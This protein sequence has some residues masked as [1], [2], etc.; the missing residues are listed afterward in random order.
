M[1]LNLRSARLPLALAAAAGLVA[2]VANI[3]YS[4][5]KDFVAD[6]TASSISTTVPVDL[7]QYKEVQDHKGGVEYL[8]F[9]SADISVATIPATNKATKVTGKVSLRAAGSPAD[10]S[11]DVVVGQLTN[12]AI[13]ASSSLHLPGSP[14]LDAFLLAQIKGPGQFSVAITGATDG[15]AHFTLHAKINASLGSGSF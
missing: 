1:K 13:S 15:E 12:F 6:T 9:N 3:D 14:A 7:G 2:C 10:G 11:A 5:D 8:H 4:M